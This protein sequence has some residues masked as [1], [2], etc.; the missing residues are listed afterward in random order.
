MHR[1]IRFCSIL[2]TAD[3]RAV[4]RQLELCVLDPFFGYSWHHSDCFIATQSHSEF[5]LEHH[6]KA[7]ELLDIARN[8]AM[9]ENTIVRKETSKSWSEREN[10]PKFQIETWFLK[11]LTKSSPIK[12]KW[13]SSL[14][15]IILDPL[16]RSKRSHNDW[17]SSFSFETLL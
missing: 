1:L 5:K 2:L 8:V 9:V 16:R 17:W 13:F 11:D 7:K 15:T 3:S 4:D 6:E 14:P 12:C 10:A